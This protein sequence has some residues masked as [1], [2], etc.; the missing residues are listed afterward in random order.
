MAFGI[1]RS[2]MNIWKDKVLSGEIAYL[3]HYWIDHRFPGIRTVTKVGCA[4]LVKLGSWCEQHGLE[5]RYI[6]RREKFPHFDLF[7]RKQKEIL[8]KEQQWEQINR[9]KL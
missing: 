1:N 7:G 6:H 4:D 5:P 3:T 2:E 8:I 9:F